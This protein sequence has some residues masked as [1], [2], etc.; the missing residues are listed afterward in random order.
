[1]NAY[2][3]ELLVLYEFATEL[4]R[5]VVHAFAVSFKVALLRAF[6]EVK[7]VGAEGRLR[8]AIFAAP[9]P[10]AVSPVRTIECS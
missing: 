10:L 3:V 1:M 6:V 9:I 2:T 4:V 8:D 5:V 7:A